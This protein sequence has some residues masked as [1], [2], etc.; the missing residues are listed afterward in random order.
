MTCPPSQGTASSAD[1]CQ[2]AVIELDDAHLG[3]DAAGTVRAF[4]RRTFAVGAIRAAQWVVGR[5]P[6][7]YDMAD[8]LGLR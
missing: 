4:D 7:L 5:T 6:G 2:T 3:G 8:V 1:A